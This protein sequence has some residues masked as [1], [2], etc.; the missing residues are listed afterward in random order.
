MYYH[1]LT[2]KKTRKSIMYYF[3][4]QHRPLSSKKPK[5]HHLTRAL[6]ASSLL[7]ASISLH[8]AQLDTFNSLRLLFSGEHI[9]WI[10]GRVGDW[11]NPEN[12]EGGSVP[13]SQD[14]ITVKGGGSEANIK[15]DFVGTLSILEGAKVTLTSDDFFRVGQQ[16]SGNLIV[17]NGGSLE[18]TAGTDISSGRS[19]QGSVTIRGVNSQWT[20]KTKSSLTIGASGGTG[21][22]DIENA[23]NLT[24]S[25]YRVPWRQA[26]PLEP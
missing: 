13:D 19:S 16:G 5:L 23:G 3:T 25:R 8:A 11:D 21:Q 4:T 12:W 24:T 9:S 7:C 20:H 10:E 15:D 14:F 17:D 18:T 6:F 22:V 2:N 1:G 26:T